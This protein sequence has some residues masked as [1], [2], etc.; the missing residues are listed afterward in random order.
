M[1][2]CP[3]SGLWWWRSRAWRRGTCRRCGSWGMGRARARDALADVPTQGVRPE[4]VQA[5][6]EP[7]YAQVPVDKLVEMRI[8]GVTP[9]YGREMRD[10]GFDKLS[11][12]KLIE[13]RI[14]GVDGDYVR[15]MGKA[16]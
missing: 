5:V 10:A 11:V 3:R 15:K 8:Q 2:S 6:Q 14:Q 16:W 9:K 13:M 12:D 7:G 1:R 4:F